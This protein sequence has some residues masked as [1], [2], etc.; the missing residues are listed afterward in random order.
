VRFCPELARAAPATAPTS[1]VI[2]AVPTGD[3]PLKN[4]HWYD[5]PILFPIGLLLLIAS[6]AVLRTLT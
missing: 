6:Y 4:W 2:Q 1:M 5:P 3:T